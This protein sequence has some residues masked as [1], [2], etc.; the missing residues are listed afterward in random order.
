VDVR[1]REIG[2]P[3][4]GGARLPPPLV[5]TATP[6]GERV[7]ALLQRRLRL[8]ALLSLLFATRGACRRRLDRNAVVVCT[9]AVVWIV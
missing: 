2:A 7:L 8:R 5:A 4:V 9:V 6:L 1:R 3:R